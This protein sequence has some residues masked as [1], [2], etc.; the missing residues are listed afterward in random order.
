MRSFSPISCC[1]IVA[2]ISISCKKSIVDDRLK[3]SWKLAAISFGARMSG[4]TEG[5]I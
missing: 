2:I 3:G 4:V 1:L 5:G